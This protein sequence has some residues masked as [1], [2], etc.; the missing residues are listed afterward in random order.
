MRRFATQSQI[1]KFCIQT[2]QK[3]MTHRDEHIQKK[4][5]TC[6]RWEKPGTMRVATHVKA[7]RGTLEP[8]THGSHLMWGY[9]VLLKQTAF[10][11]AQMRSRDKGRRPHG[12]LDTVGAHKHRDTL[13][14]PYRD[15]QP[16][17]GDAEGV[18]TTRVQSEKDGYS[19]VITRQYCQVTM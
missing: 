8:N 2:S 4:Q 13:G 10:K 14:M 9:G 12:C 7:E 19:L 1:S 17:G 16:L 15:K 11:C 18:S 3:Y 5:K 6:S